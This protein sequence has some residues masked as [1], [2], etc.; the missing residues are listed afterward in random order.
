MHLNPHL[1][2]SKKSKVKMEFISSHRRAGDKQTVRKNDC[3]I[4]VAAVGVKQKVKGSGVGVVGTAAAA[5][6]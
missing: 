5:Q 1:Q 3:K 2:Y 4:R 6:S